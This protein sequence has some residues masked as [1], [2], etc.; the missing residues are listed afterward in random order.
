VLLE[1]QEVTP[2]PPENETISKNWLQQREVN[3]AVVDVMDINNPR[4]SASNESTEMSETAEKSVNMIRL[5]D[6]IERS[7]RSKRKRPR[8]MAYFLEWG[9][10]AF[11]FPAIVKPVERVPFP[12]S[13][14]TFTD[15]LENRL[16]PSSFRRVRPR[17]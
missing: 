13:L 1:P 3:A 17:I 5:R 4:R 16:G 11:R 14:E 2:S 6:F 12:F 8:L 10:S 7:D 9:D 15:L